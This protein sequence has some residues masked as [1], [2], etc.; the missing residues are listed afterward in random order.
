MSVMTVASVLVVVARVL[1]PDV[2][3]LVHAAALRAALDG[4]VARRGQPDDDVGVGG[5]AG[6]AEVLLVAIGLDD[7]WVRE[8]S[9]FGSN[10]ATWHVK[11][12]GN[13]WV[14]REA[15]SRT[16]PAGIQWPHVEDVDALHLSENFE[17]LETGRLLEVVG[18]RSGL[19]SWWQKVVH[20]LDF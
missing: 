10:L 3:E 15:W 12:T 8:G 14:L 4:S 9:C 16:P 20:G 7:D 17:T 18:D 19:S 2:F 5:R 13:G 1:G 6:A 11:G